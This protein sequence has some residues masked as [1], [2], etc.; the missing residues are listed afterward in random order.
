MSFLSPLIILG[1]WTKPIARDF[2]HQAPIGEMPS[3]LCESG[4][5]GR[6]GSWGPLCVP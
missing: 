4:G 2:L 5:A 1:L 6:E 3:S